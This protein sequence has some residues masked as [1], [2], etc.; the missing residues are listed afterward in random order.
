MRRGKRIRWRDSRSTLPARRKRRRRRRRDVERG[1]TYYPMEVSADAAR[2]GVRS[3]L[4]GAV[5]AV[6]L[7]V[8]SVVAGMLAPHSFGAILGFTTGLCSLGAAVGL[9][10]SARHE[11]QVHALAASLEDAPLLE[12]DADVMDVEPKQMA[13]EPERIALPAA[14][15]TDGAV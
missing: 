11:E 10:M 1:G 15:H 3:R 6:L 12:S 8:L 2:S 7:T 9:L 4:Y 5:L 13:D 14:D